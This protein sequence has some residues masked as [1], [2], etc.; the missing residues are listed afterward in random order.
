[1]PKRLLLKFE[2]AIGIPAQVLKLW[3]FLLFCFFMDADTSVVLRSYTIWTVVIPT[4]PNYLSDNDLVVLA[5]V[6]F[7]YAFCFIVLS[8]LVDRYD[9]LVALVCKK[10][11]SQ[12]SAAVSF[13]LCVSS[14]SIKCTRWMIDHIKLSGHFQVEI[15]IQACRIGHT[16]VVK[17]LATEHPQF[18]TWP[19]IRTIFNSNNKTMV[20]WVCTLIK[21][22]PEAAVRISGALASTCRTEN[23]EIT[24]YLVSNFDLATLAATS[25]EVREGV[26]NAF[27][28]SCEKGHLEMAQWLCLNC[29]LK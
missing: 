4:W 27:R 6:F 22:R 19:A 25:Q 24:K 18:L 8:L 2:V 16:E 23:F 13:D 1:M 14:Y 15:F 3:F 5:D 26:R 10:L 29:K 9:R 11:L 21:G 28:T 20:D 17:K 12:K 7:P